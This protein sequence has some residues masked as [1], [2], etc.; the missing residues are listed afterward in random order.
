MSD[1]LLDLSGNKRA[2]GVIEKL[3]LPVP[4]PENLKRGRGELLERPLHD[5]KVLVA[6][7]VSGELHGVIA[8]T[9]AR[10]G[11]EVGAIES[12]AEV[13][14]Y[15]EAGE[16]YARPVH[17]LPLEPTE[18]GRYHA[19]VFDAST[20]DTTEELRALYDVVHHWI[21]NLGK[22]ARLIVL[23]RPVEEAKTVEQA[24]ARGALEGFVRSCAKEIGRKGSTANLIRVAKGAEDRVEPLLRFLLSP[25]SAYVSGQPFDVTATVKAPVAEIPRSRVLDGKAILLTGAARGIGKATAKRLAAEGARLLLLDRP[26]DGELLAEVANGIEG[27]EI[28]LADVTDPE[29][30]TIIAEAARE[31]FGGLDGVVHNAGVTRDKT[32]GKMRP[33]LWDMTLDINLA[34]INR[35][36]DALLDGVLRDESRIVLL[37]SIAGIGGNVG[38]TNYAASKSGVIGATRFLAQQLGKRGIAVNAIAPGFIETRLTAAIPVATREVARRLSNLSQGGLPVDIGEMAVFLLSPGAYGL[39]GDVHRVCGGN[40]MG[41]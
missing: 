12:A 5:A 27:A 15:S 20:L 11:A 21:R 9:V 28:V 36:N 24:G 10:C 25:E 7:P 26:A 30:P 41:A 40:L 14:A 29:A 31:H 13:A 23:G 6:G 16:A 35:I 39:T 34:A 22:S 8:G 33:E 2:R 17:T 38:Q 37:S 1:F 4:M 3:G 32:I 19:L 18:K